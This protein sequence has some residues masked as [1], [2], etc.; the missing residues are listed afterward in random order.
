MKKLIIGSDLD[1]CILDTSPR[2][3]EEFKKEFGIDVELAGIPTNDIASLYK[4]DRRRVRKAINRV[5]ESYIEP[6]QHSIPVIK[7]LSFVA[8]RFFIIS[9]RS[10]ELLPQTI[11]NLSK[12]GLDLNRITVILTSYPDKW[13]LINQHNI[14]IFIEDKPH[15]IDGIIHH[16]NATVLV[17]DRPH[18]QQVGEGDRVYV[19]QRW[20]EIRNFV[21]NRLDDE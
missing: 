11:D 15:I 3:K 1:D 18:N 10:F 21:L 9:N 4:L 19:V 5:L 12:A 6:I 14:D 8:E 20:Y 16:T 2:L 13:E 17:F 7:F